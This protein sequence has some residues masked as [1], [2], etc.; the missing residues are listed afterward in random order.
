MKTRIILAALCAAMPVT[1]ASAM[2]V[3]AFLQKADALEKKGMMALF[4]SDYKL[5]SK[6]VETAS[7]QLR[8]DRLAAQKAG[9]TPAYCPPA[10]GGGMQPKEMLALLRTIP[11]AQRARLELKDGLKAVLGRKFPCG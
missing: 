6:E 1:A 7:G 3:A 5:L 2:N 9:R 4:S 10:K 8:A 11:V